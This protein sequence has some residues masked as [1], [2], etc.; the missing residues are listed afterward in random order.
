[1]LESMSKMKL[2]DAPV[3]RPDNP[4][5]V[6]ELVLK[7]KSLEKGE[8]VTTRWLLEKG[9]VT[10]AS[11]NRYATHPRLMPYRRGTRGVLTQWWAGK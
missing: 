10:T 6:R 7:L 2:K 11:L 4:P 8:F 3:R 9:W 5:A 1:M